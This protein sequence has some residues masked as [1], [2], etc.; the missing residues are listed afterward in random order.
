M[1]PAIDPKH[2]D[3]W[4]RAGGDDGQVHFLEG[5][6]VEAPQQAVA[7]RDRLAADVQPDRGMRRLHP[8]QEEQ[9]ADAPGHEVLGRDHDAGLAQP[10]QQ[11]GDLEDPVPSPRPG[12]K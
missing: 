3:S 7:R 6:V 12:I 8:Q 10:R 1:T 5:A 9:D 11:P 4:N 2:I